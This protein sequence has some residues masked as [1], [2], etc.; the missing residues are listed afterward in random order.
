MYIYIYMHIYIYTYMLFVFSTDVAAACVLTARRLRTHPPLRCRPYLWTTLR[1]YLAAGR[2]TK[3]VCAR[4]T[5]CHSMPSV[6]S[7]Q[8]GRS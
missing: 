8:S 2:V 3:I 4:A 7:R 5:S 6:Y 1:D